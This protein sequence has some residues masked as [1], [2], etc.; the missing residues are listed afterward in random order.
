M[1]YHKKEFVWYMT[2]LKFNREIYRELDVERF[3]DQIIEF[4]PNYRNE[5][6]FMCKFFHQIF[7][8][9]PR[10]LF[11]KKPYGILIFLSKKP[12]EIINKKY[13][14][15][16][17]YFRFKIGTRIYILKFPK[18]VRELM[19]SLFSHVEIISI[20]CDLS[21]RYDDFFVSN[22]CKNPYKQKIR[23]FIKLKDSDI[24][25]ALGYKG[26]YIHLINVFLKSFSNF[27][28]YLRS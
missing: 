21:T 11:Q 18:T 7:G 10:L 4:K 16:L 5:E 8:F 25:L 13:I 22:E 27:N 14:N 20:N 17:N 19:D 6:I 23:I 9:Y 24:P 3:L 2:N 1:V 28:I 15:E 26:Y 12:F